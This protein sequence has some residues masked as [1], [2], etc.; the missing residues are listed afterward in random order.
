M[1]SHLC[2]YSCGKLWYGMGE[3]NVESG[4]NG[5]KQAILGAKLV[6]GDYLLPDTCTTR[7][8]PTIWGHC[9]VCKADLIC[10]QQPVLG[11]ETGLNLKHVLLAI[12]SFFQF[13]SSKLF[14]HRGRHDPMR[15]GASL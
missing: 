11:P 8:R 1:F 15:T 12:I 14:G 2:M 10:G 6:Y 7:L 9:Q 3:S 5:I 4:L 13:G